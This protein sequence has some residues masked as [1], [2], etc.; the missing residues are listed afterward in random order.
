MGV[1]Q[2]SISALDNPP[3]ELVDALLDEQR[4]ERKIM[5]GIRYKHHRG[6]SDAWY[7]GYSAYVGGFRPDN[8]A[9]YY[10]T[11]GDMKAGYEQ[12]IAD[13]TTPPMEAP[14]G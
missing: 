8:G 6:K 1:Q 3:Q 9:S 12:A 5:R 11:Y 2:M 13:D 10:D 14:R 7:N 4:R